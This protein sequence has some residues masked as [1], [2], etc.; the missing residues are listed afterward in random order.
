MICTAPKAACQGRAVSR[1]ASICAK[2]A[3]KVHAVTGYVRGYRPPGIT[4]QNTTRLLG[5]RRTAMPTGCTL[6]KAK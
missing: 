4:K 5:L 6:Q 3:A 1:P 2:V